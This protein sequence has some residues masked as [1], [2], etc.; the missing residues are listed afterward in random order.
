MLKY[1]TKNLIEG[2]GN[3]T[4]YLLLTTTHNNTVQGRLWNRSTSSG[5]PSGM[6]LVEVDGN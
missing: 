3:Q 2:V 6:H 1:S 5:N 4:F